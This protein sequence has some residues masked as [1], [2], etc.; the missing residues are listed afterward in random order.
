MIYNLL[1]PACRKC[2]Y[3][4]NVTKYLVLTKDEVEQGDEKLKEL[5]SEL[6]EMG[7]Y[8][9]DFSLGDILED[10]EEEQKAIEPTKRRLPDF[11]TIE[12]EESVVEYVGQY[13]KQCV[14]R[15][16]L[17]K[18]VKERLDKDKASGHETLIFY[19]YGHGTCEFSDVIMFWDC[20]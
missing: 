19:S 4:A 1:T 14:S 13:K 9:S 6:Q 18:N 3:D 12:G 5:E 20:S 16:A 2:I 17:L 15:K 10:P 7:L 8:D 11:P